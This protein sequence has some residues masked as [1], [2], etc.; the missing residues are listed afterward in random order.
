MWG[1]LP[2]GRGSAEML[3]EREADPNGQ[4]YEGG[5]LLSQAYGMIARFKPFGG[6]ECQG[7]GCQKA[8]KLRYFLLDVKGPKPRKP[9]IDYARLF[10]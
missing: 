3:L 1:V 6:R 10:Q 7:P 4:V 8:I 5:T 2:D 9:S